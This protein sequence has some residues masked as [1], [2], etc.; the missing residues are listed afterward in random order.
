MGRVPAGAGHVAVRLRTTSPWVFSFNH[1]KTRPVGVTN[2]I[3]G[4]RPKTVRGTLEPRL[5]PVWHQPL[6]LC[7]SPI[8]FLCVSLLRCGAQ[9]GEGVTRAQGYGYSARGGDSPIPPSPPSPSLPPPLLHSLPSHAARSP[10]PLPILLSHTFLSF[11][12]RFSVVGPS[13]H[14]NRSDLGRGGGRGVG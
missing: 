6:L 7:S 9:R 2:Q 4:V 12:Q 10:L 1:Q 8:S 11:V 3:M 5:M 13:L 14:P